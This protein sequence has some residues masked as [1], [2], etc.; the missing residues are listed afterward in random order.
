[1]GSEIRLRELGLEVNT[2]EL[3]QDFTRIYSALATY[4]SLNG[5]LQVPHQFKIPHGSPDYPQ[6]AWDMKLG[7]IVKGIRKNDTFS[8]Y[9]PQLEELGFV[10]STNNAKQQ[11]I[12]EID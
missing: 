8:V 3:V 5:D 7:A 2:N 11:Q 4:K 12:V 10:Y 6:S 1:M 9:R